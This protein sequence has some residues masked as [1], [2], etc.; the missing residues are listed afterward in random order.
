MAI[1]FLDLF[2]G[3]GGLPA[4]PSR[5]QHRPVLRDPEQPPGQSRRAGRPPL[6]TSETQGIYCIDN[7]LLQQTTIPDAPFAV[8]IQCSDDI[9]RTGRVRKLLPI[10]CWRLQGFTDEQF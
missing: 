1:R 7:E 3:M 5:R 10:E 8:Q 4:R 6:T 9:T 2:A